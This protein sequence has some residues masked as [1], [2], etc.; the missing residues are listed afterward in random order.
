M[1]K[2]NYSPI[3]R[4][5]QNTVMKNTLF[6][7]FCAAFLLTTMAYLMDGDPKPPRMAVRFAE[8]AAVLAIL[9]LIISVLWFSS[10]FLL[11]K[12]HRA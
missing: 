12:L 6:K 11:R 2:H 3:I 1:Q 9:Y 4:P 7:L 10:R 8:F 5:Y